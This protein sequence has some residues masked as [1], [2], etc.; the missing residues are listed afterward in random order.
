MSLYREILEKNRKDNLI[1]ENDKI[2]VG[3]SG[4]P[5][6]VFLVEMLMKL[7][8]SINFDIQSYKIYI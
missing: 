8:K 6:S 2:V 1:V 7:K 5:D 3:F 4:G